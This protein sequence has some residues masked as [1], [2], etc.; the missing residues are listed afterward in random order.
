MA[1]EKYIIVKLI[2]LWQ[3]LLKYLRH[4]RYL[5]AGLAL[6]CWAPSPQ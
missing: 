3:G 1:K 5:L 6:V 2:D 4:L